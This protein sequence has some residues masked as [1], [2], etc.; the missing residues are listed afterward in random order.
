MGMDVSELLRSFVGGLIHNIPMWFVLLF[1]LIIYFSRRD[2]RPRAAGFVLIA[3]IVYGLHMLLTP[4][5]YR[6]VFGALAGNGANPGEFTFQIVGAVISLP[7][8]LA[9]GLLFY[10]ALMPD[11]GR[12]GS[13]R[14]YRRRYNDDE[15]YE[16]I[17]E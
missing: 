15:D 2:E 14:R 17:D 6:I 10:A 13:S 1:A 8:V 7:S 4:L 9:H 3:I 5:A 12:G 11:D 16:T